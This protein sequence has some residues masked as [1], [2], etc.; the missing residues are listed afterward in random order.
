MT[1]TRNAA[2]G[3]FLLCMLA[4]GCQS[5]SGAGHPGTGCELRKG[6]T[7]DELVQCGCVAANAGSASVASGADPDSAETLRTVTVGTYSCPLGGAGLA[8]VSV[9]NGVADEIAY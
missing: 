3:T 1:G 6:M 9:L 2:I 4:V 8:R 5:R 7:I